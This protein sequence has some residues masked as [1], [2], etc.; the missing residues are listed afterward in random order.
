MRGV[1]DPADMFRGGRVG[2]LFARI[3]AGMAHQRDRA[4]ARD[5][6]F[7]GDK[8]MRG[9]WKRLQR[10]TDPAK[11]A[12]AFYEAA[13]ILSGMAARHRTAFGPQPNPHE[14]GRDHAE[15]VSHSANL[16][17][18]LGLV[19]GAVADPTTDLD[20]ELTDGLLALSLDTPAVREVLHRMAATADLRERATIAENALYDAVV[21]I[22]GGQ[23]AETI[24]SVPAPVR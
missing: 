12:D 22:V 4:E 23:A 16:M 24:A 8:A 1:M 3:R 13:D 14:G 19:E 17:F 10:E 15:S 21:P 11:R 2:R 18:V 9:I 7:A 5:Q 6:Y 20:G